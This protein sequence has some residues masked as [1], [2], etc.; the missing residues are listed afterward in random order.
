[1]PL[2]TATYLDTLD[3]ANP[4]GTDQVREAD[5]HLR[6]IKQVLQNTFPQI[7]AAVT[8]NATELNLLDGLTE[9]PS[10][11]TPAYPTTLV[12][13]TTL[14][15]INNDLT[16]T[17]I[18]SDANEIFVRMIDVNMGS[19]SPPI[20]Q[21]G[22]G[23]VITSGYDG[24]T[25]FVGSGAAQTQFHVNDIQLHGNT[26][27]NASANGNCVMSFVKVPGTD[28]WQY[29]GHSWAWGASLEGSSIA[30]FIDLA[31]LFDT[32]RISSEAAAAALDSGTIQAW[33]R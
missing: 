4:A 27:C 33:W 21:V 30:G 31:G 12:E 23:G 15:Q 8:A 26:S 11:G 32:I 18:T 10:A 13:D 25:F 7:N 22:S 29:H 5:N 14:D 6:L 20:M 17:G 16:L 2:E 28:I 24:N 9:I 1:M 19:T 3:P